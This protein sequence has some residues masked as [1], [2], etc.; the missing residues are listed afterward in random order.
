MYAHLRTE[1]LFVSLTF[2]ILRRRLYKAI[3]EMSLCSHYRNLELITAHDGDI[4]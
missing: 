4:I 3:L 2:F 1:H